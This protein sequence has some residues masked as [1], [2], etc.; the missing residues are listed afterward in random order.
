MGIFLG[1]ELLLGAAFDA[2]DRAVV[3]EDDLDIVRELAMEVR[4][5]LPVGL[6]RVQDGVALFLERVDL[7]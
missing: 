3:R 6:A 1:L 2:L 5:V 7:V 4:D